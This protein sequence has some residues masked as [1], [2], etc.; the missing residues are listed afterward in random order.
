MRNCCATST[1]N[2]T[3]PG[4]YNMV[5]SWIASNTHENQV[6]DT[7]I[8]VN[9]GQRVLMMHRM[10]FRHIINP[11]STEYRRFLKLKRVDFVGV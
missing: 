11:K 7:V 6:F 3:K 4:M 9:E 1:S 8:Q 10:F 2:D 5:T